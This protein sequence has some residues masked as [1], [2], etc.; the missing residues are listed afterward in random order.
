MVLSKMSIR[1]LIH[2]KR[3]L[4]FVLSRTIWHE[5]GMFMDILD[6]TKFQGPF[7][8][9]PNVFWSKCLIDILDKTKCL[10]TVSLLTLLSPQSSS[11]VIVT[12]LLESRFTQSWVEYTIF[13]FSFFSKYS[14]SFKTPQ[15]AP[16]LSD[17]CLPLNSYITHCLH[18]LSGSW[19]MLL[20]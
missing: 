11:Y 16:T 19:H 10:L 8:C 20:V 17:F 13:T 1:N 12:K 3:S 6:R 15:T 4:L 7:W 14:F 2:A 5:P 9:G 18:L